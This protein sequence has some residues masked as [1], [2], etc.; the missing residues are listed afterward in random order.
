MHAVLSKSNKQA[1]IVK[2]EKRLH[3]LIIA[4]RCMRLLI[5]L[6]NYISSRQNFAITNYDAELFIPSVTGSRF[7]RAR[8]R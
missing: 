6:Y 4:S 5:F 1:S 7:Q 8:R 2:N 3:A